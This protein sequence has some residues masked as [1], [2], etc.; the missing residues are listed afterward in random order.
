M[1]Q[2]RNVRST[3]KR[4]RGIPSY[5]RRKNISMYTSYKQ[6]SINLYKKEEETKLMQESI[7]WYTEH[8]CRV[9]KSHKGTGYQHVK[10]KRTRP[11]TTFSQTFTN[12]STENCTTPSQPLGTLEQSNKFIIIK[13][14]PKIYNL[15]HIHL[16]PSISNNKYI[17]CFF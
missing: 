5:R 3:E 16:Y 6:T 13:S 7:D 14:I 1:S 2:S 12:H 4:A 8:N 10:P 11:N 15:P 17:Y 9:N